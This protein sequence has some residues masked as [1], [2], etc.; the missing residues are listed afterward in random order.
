MTVL[1][2]CNCNKVLDQRDIPY[3]II[4]VGDLDQYLCRIC[5]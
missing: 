3:T 1:Q 4:R 2:C 5:G